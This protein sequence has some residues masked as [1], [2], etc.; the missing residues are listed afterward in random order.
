MADARLDMEVNLTGVSEVVRGLDSVADSTAKIRRVA[1]PTTGGIKNL[2]KALGATQKAASSANLAFAGFGNL[3]R[4][5]LVSGFSQLASSAKLAWSA[6]GSIGTG[7]AATV[8]VVAAAVA[9]NGIAILSMY[10][11]WMRAHTEADRFLK[12]QSGAD[13]ANAGVDASAASAGQVPPR[14]P[15]DRAVAEADI[16]A[17]RGELASAW[18][19]L[20][21]KT[22]Q[23]RQY[24]QWKAEKEFTGYSPEDLK[25]KEHGDI[26]FQADFDAAKKRVDDL[27][28]AERKIVEM[29]H[30]T[31]LETARIEREQTELRND[32]IRK[33]HQAEFD[34]EKTASAAEYQY[35]LSQMSK[36]DRLKAEQIALDTLSKKEQTPEVRLAIVEQKMRVDVAREEL[37]VEKERQAAEEKADATARKRLSDQQKAYQLAQKE[38]EAAAAASE[39]EARQQIIAENLAIEGHTRTDGF[40]GP[41]APDGFL[42]KKKSRFKR[43]GRQGAGDNVTDRFNA[44]R[45]RRFAAQGID[46]VHTTKMGRPDIGAD[47][48]ANPTERTNVLLEKLIE[49]LS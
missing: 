2:S 36:E 14:D 29:R 31:A 25:N 33:R 35:K 43:L 16:R 5:N 27:A 49:K 40:A 21:E 15:I 30:N 38:R 1:T 28:E 45:M 17:I 6:I 42:L 41:E 18:K 9:A 39:K 26:Q 34:A 32:E 11:T 4:G 22:H 48:K 13:R 8:G 20:D 47:G 37:R 7:A 23:L 44:D 19:D 3:L 46:L 24:N 12:A 10:R